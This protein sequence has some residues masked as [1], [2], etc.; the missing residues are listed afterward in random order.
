MYDCRAVSERKYGMTKAIQVQDITLEDSSCEKNQVFA[1][2]DRMGGEDAGEAASFLA[3]EEW[4]KYPDIPDLPGM[5]EAKAESM[6]LEGVMN[7][8]FVGVWKL[9]ICAKNW[10]WFLWKCI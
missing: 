10:K 4:K 8:E 9:G 5:N 1:I 7:F 6:L 2:C 3:V